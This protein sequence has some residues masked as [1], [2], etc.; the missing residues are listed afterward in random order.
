MFRSDWRERITNFERTFAW[1]TLI[2]AVAFVSILVI[3]SA[4][5]QSSQQQKDYAAKCHS[6]KN[7]YVVFLNSI[8]SWPSTNISKAEVSQEK[9]HREKTTLWC[10]LAAQQTAAESSWIAAKE[11]YLVRWLTA[12]G[13]LLIGLTLVYTRTTLR[14]AKSATEAARETTDVAKQEQ[15][16]WLR[17][18]S[19]KITNFIR[20]QLE[21]SLPK[22]GVVH[23]YDC[24]CEVNIENVGN[25]PAE[26]V[27]VWT[28]AVPGFIEIEQPP[29]GS[30][31][32]VTLNNGIVLHRRGVEREIETSLTAH[33]RGEERIIFPQGEVEKFIGR[34][35]FSFVENPPSNHEYYRWSLVVALSY[36]VR[37][38][39]DFKKTIKVFEICN[40]CAGLGDDHPF[41]DEPFPELKPITRITLIPEGG[42][43]AT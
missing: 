14:E 1:G 13:V 18:H 10:N 36:K 37:G 26:N 11:A 4:Q 40:P 15:R 9:A 43:R 38:S 16:A 24:E 41:L 21:T 2:V 27:S 3:Q 29:T 39:N 31:Q 28:S 6:A 8:A 25:S 5:P 23:R 30:G 32:S 33:T 20:N 12:L 42:D 7:D 34:Y 19:V 22:L 17:I 35:F